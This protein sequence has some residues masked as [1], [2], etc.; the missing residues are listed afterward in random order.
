MT[1]L[2]LGLTPV[3]VS[4]GRGTSSPLLM[5]VAAS[6]I[7]RTKVLAFRKQVAHVLHGSDQRLVQNDLKVSIRKGSMPKK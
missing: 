6:S 5:P 1:T 3:L 4:S 2:P 7:S